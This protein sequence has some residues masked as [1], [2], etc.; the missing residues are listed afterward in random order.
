MPHFTESETAIIQTIAVYV[1]LDRLTRQG[2]LP[3]TASAEY[4]DG[5]GEDKKRIL[6]KYLFEERRLMDQV[7]EGMAESE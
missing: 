4:Y 3:K 5:L 1:F 7:R 6:N 2:V